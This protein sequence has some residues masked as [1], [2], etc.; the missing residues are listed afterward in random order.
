MIIPA[1]LTSSSCEFKR[2]L[3]ICKTFT[4][5]VQIDIMD[6]IFVPS[7]S[8][9]PDTIELT[10]T[11]L[12]SEAHLMVKDPF[13]WLEAF[14][15]FGTS[16]IIFH[17]EAVD[18]PLEVIKKIKNYNFEVGMAINPKTKISDFKHLVDKV[19]TIL[20]MSVNPGFYG[21]EFIPTVL[22][23]IKKF[24]KIYPKKIVG[25]DGGI[26]LDNIKKVISSN[27]DYICVGSAILKS[28]NPKKM[29]LKLQEQLKEKKL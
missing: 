21:S 23:K 4:N 19:D 16:R 11:D 9:Q 5:Y 24:K 20:F 28:D 10:K 1:I 17:F 25:I 18:E 13:L 12:K 8:I 2:M 29:Y 14:K 15:K 3:K 6:G 22:E 7:K 26:K 27:T